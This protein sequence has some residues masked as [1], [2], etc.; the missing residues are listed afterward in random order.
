MKR[1]LIALL[2]CL[3]WPLCV[4]ASS[5]EISAAWSP[6]SDKSLDLPVY[7]SIKNGGEND[8]LL[9]VKCPTVAHFTEKRTT[10]HGEGAPSVREVKAISVP[11]SA[12]TELKPGGLHIALLKIMAP[13]IVGDQFSCEITFRRAG[14][15]NVN[16][17]VRAAG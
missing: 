12:T 5:L 8:D 16:V 9:R 11:G 15:V 7:M 2:L 10:D 13:T 6:A 1:C 14:R 3:L 4:A 17:E